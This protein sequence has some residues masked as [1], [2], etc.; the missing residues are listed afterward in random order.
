[1]L[2]VAVRRIPNAP[3]G[4]VAA[5]LGELLVSS[6]LEVFHPPP[7]VPTHEAVPL[8][9][10]DPFNR[11]YSSGTGKL[12]SGI[13]ATNCGQEH[14]DRVRIFKSHNV[15]GPDMDTDHLIP[16]FVLR[17][18]ALMEGKGTSPRIV[19]PIQGSGEEGRSFLDID[20]FIA[21]L[22]ESSNGARTAIFAT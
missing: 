21:S 1:M 11:P 18:N 16:V 2:E 20:D 13:L 7:V 4:C 9:V 17:L 8:I 15:F 10:P 14:L 5:G 22:S 12:I 3:N 6:R 19:F